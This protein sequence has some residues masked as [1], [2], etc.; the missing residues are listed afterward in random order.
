MLQFDVVNQSGTRQITLFVLVEL[1]MLSLLISQLFMIVGQ[2]PILFYVS[3]CYVV[4]FA[5]YG[6]NKD[7][8]IYIYT[9]IS[10]VLEHQQYC[11]VLISDHSLKNT[12]LAITTIWQ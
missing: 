2:L 1:F 4:M 11:C 8:Y 6:R 12:D 5:V 10:L 9:H 3:L 7:I